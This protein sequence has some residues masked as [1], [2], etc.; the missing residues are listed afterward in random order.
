MLSGG[1]LL[2]AGALVVAAEVEGAAIIPPIL[3][4]IPPHYLFA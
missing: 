1:Q 3:E 4:L 2:L